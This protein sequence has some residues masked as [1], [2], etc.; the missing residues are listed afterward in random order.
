MPKLTKNVMVNGK[1][2]L[3]GRTISAANVKKFGIGDHVFETGKPEKKA[4]E[5]V[6]VE[7]ESE[8]ESDSQAQEDQED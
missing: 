6:P 8:T 2:L 4:K 3:E 5:Q 7:N 1:V